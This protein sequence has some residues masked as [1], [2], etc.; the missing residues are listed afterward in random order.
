MPFVTIT[1][2]ERDSR[3]AT[4][5]PNQP[6]IP[7]QQLK[8]EFDAPA[9][10]I[11]VPKFNTLVSQLESET[12]ASDIGAFDPLGGVSSVQGEL[13]S[14][15]TSVASLESSE[16]TPTERADWNGKSTVT[17]NQ[18]VTTGTR[19]AD[20]TID[21]NTQSIY[22]TGGGG[23]GSGAVDSVN[24][25]VGDVIVN[26]GDI[27]DVTLTNVAPN[28]ALIKD[29]TGWVNVPLPLVALT[30]SYGDL[31]NTPTIPTTDQ[32]YSSTSPNPQS[33]VAVSQG[34]ATKADASAV[35]QK[36]TGG[37]F[38][39]KSSSTGASVYFDGVDPNKS[40][41]LFANYSNSYNGDAVAY[42]KV[43]IENRGTTANPNYRITFTLKNATSNQSFKLYE[44]DGN[45]S[46]LPYYTGSYSASPRTV[47][48]SLSTANKS[49]SQNVVVDAINY[50][51]TLNEAGG[52]TATIGYD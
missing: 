51:E 42:T 19:I 8:E 25:M 28:D 31:Q 16:V 34:L 9:K 37:L 5:L 10:E 15:A 6:T 41:K 18:V 44:I 21:G 35:S 29:A 27:E 48:Q 1:D 11:V 17:W 22:S 3:G 33:G 40:Y 4:T 49:M 45:P 14:L 30:G 23:G 50:D 7:A 2:V 24:H 39:T 47:A 36:L 32:I 52:Y 12:A 46:I 43:K 26:V 38:G 13:N 20:I